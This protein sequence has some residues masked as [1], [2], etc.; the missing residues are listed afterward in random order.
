MTFY[1]TNDIE[2]VYSGHFFDADTKR[3]FR[4]RIGETVYG[5]RYFITS[6][7]FDSRSPR[8]YTVREVSADGQNITTVGD[9]QQHATRA[10][11]LAAINWMIR[12]REAAAAFESR[13]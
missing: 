6:E 1:T 9:F 12:E 7:Q 3:F 13:T 2:R 8:L 11:A 10:Q 5:G 4:S